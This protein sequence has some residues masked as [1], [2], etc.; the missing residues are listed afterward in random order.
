MK[1]NWKI[2]YFAILLGIILWLIDGASETLYFTGHYLWDAI[3][4]KLP[5]NEIYGRS[6]TFIIILFSGLLLSRTIAKQKAA[7]DE[8]TKVNS[9]LETRIGQRTYK[10][11]QMNEELEAEVNKHR[12]TAEMLR[13]SESRLRSI[14]LQILTAQEKERKEISRELHDEFGQTLAS[15]KQHLWRIEKKLKVEETELKDEVQEGLQ[16]V[17]EVIE[18]VRRISRN[19]SPYILEY[20]GLLTALRKLINDFSA[21]YNI[22]VTAELI[23]TDY[24]IPKEFHVALYRIFQEALNNIGKHACATR[25]TVQISPND[26]G[27]S[28]HIEDNGKGFSVDQTILGNSTGE[29]LGLAI[30]D[31][32]VKMLGGRLNLWSQ[33]GKGTRI[34]FSIPATPMSGTSPL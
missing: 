5:P 33:E 10:L 15:L 14:S 6:I 11:R 34:S 18:N 22:D 20:G 12:K 24:A 29:G 9:E 16:N 27:I 30:L 23:D 25:V 7:E 31:E 17:A 26:H 28:C 21:H 3:I 1:L 2:I 8:L 19:L 13:E 4:L 32:R